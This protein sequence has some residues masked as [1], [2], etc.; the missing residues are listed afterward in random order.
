MKHDLEIT[1]SN[2]RNPLQY[3]SSDLSQS[4]LAVCSL[5]KKIWN[6]QIYTCKYRCKHFESMS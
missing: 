3:L 6:I 2:S 5:K 1:N 4:P